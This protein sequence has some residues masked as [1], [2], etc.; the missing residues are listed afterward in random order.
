MFVYREVFLDH[1]CSRWLE[2]HTLIKK[3]VYADII[4]TIVLS[5]LGWNRTLTIQTVLAVLVDL[6]NV[7]TLVVSTAIWETVEVA[8]TVRS[9]PSL[10]NLEIGTLYARDTE[11]GYQPLQML[12]LSPQSSWNY[13]EFGEVANMHNSVQVRNL[14]GLYSIKTLRLRGY[15]WNGWVEEAGAR[16][17][18]DVTGLEFFDVVRYSWSDVE[19]DG[20]NVP[21]VQFISEATALHRL[22]LEIPL[23]SSCGLTVVSRYDP[24]PWN[25]LLEDAAD[26]LPQNLSVLE[27]CFTFKHTSCV[28]DHKEDVKKRFKFTWDR[29]GQ[30]VSAHE[31]LRA[32]DFTFRCE[33]VDCRQ[34]TSTALL[35]ACFIHA[36]ASF[37][38]RELV[39]DHASFYRTQKDREELRLHKAT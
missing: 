21:L 33:T 10:K 34:P 12:T 29:I 38:V 9:I 20:Q 11:Y 30:L 35:V 3:H 15:N 39:D 24:A 7:Y 27:I 16:F 26:S 25:K 22:K 17:L 13:V 23:Y 1:G 37:S 31:R 6:P 28:E 14:T 19:S 32:V 8:G 36:F 4:N 18:P 2:K 5:C